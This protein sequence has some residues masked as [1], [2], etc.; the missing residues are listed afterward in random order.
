MNLT[1]LPKHKV[2]LPSPKH[3]VDPSAQF[4]EDT[5]FMTLLRSHNEYDVKLHKAP[6]PILT[7]HHHI[8]HALKYVF[9]IVDSRT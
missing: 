5:A 8:I 6:G 7:Q 9:F 4:H 1:L 2:D 3:E